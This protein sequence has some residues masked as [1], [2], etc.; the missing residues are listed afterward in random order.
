M[1]LYSKEE[2]EAQKRV[3][4]AEI[5]S[6]EEM[7]K[8]MLELD[9]RQKKGIRNE[10]VKKKSGNFYGFTIDDVTHTHL[11]KA[12]EKLNAL[13]L[14]MSYSV[15]IRDAIRNYSEMTD[16]ISNDDEIAKRAY[17]LIKSMRGI[18]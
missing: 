13:G 12:R 17:A 8:A 18:E 7:E 4:V 6:D 14:N 1:N 10:Q 16:M 11:V 3:E 2:Q 9:T 5:M 15:L